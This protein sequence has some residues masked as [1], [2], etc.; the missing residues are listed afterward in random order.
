MQLRGLRTHSAAVEDLEAAKQWYTHLLGVP[1]YFDEPFYVGFDVA[2]YEFGLWP[3]EPGVGGTLVY[4]ATEDPAA[5]IKRAVEMG[6]EANQAVQDVG[7][8][9]ILGTFLDPFGNEF[10]VI[11]NPHFAPQLTYA[12]ADDTSDEVIIYSRDVPISRQDA[13]ELWSSSEGL[14]KWWTENTKIELRPGGEYEIHFNP[15]ETPGNR[16]GDWVRVLSFLPG[17]MLSFTWNAPSE[18]KTRPLHT[19]VV[20]LFEDAEGSGARVTLNHFGWPASGLADPE[21]DWPATLD[22]FKDAWSYVM[23]LF[24]RHFENA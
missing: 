7:D 24:A 14:A 4:W 18:L 19:W 16:G 11:R 21:S 2:G 23:D 15:D 6:A 22:Y 17:R 1:P 9:I 3:G 20:L 8:G 10:G 5:F 13:W 12:K